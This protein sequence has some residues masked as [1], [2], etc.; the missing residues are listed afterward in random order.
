MHPSHPD[1]RLHG[2]EDL[3]KLD[4]PANDKDCLQVLQRYHA[5]ELGS[6]KHHAPVVRA[7]HKIK[8]VGEVVLAV[9]IITNDQHEAINEIVNACNVDQGIAGVPWVDSDTLTADR[10]PNRIFC[11][12]FGYIKC[13]GSPPVEWKKA[14]GNMKYSGHKTNWYLIME[15]GTGDT[16]ELVTLHLRLLI[17]FAFEL[18]F[19]LAAAYETTQFHHKDLHLE[20]VL[21][22]IVPPDA[23]FAARNYTVSGMAFEIASDHCPKIIDFGKV[24][25][26]ET[27]IAETYDVQYFLIHLRT[28]YAKTSEPAKWIDDLAKVAR[29]PGATFVDVLHAEAFESL[30]VERPPPSKALKSLECHVCGHVATRAYEHSPTYTF[31]EQDKCVQRMA[32]I[33]NLLL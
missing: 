7:T 28:K 13:G 21:S 31:C 32:P 22:Q 19:A 8:L 1:P 5:F 3:S 14:L 4:T 12:T 20:N 26:G 15:L 10:N 17:A 18:F 30:R 27:K 6:G 33:G 25:F 9:K 16:L 24:T 29:R 23:L 11:R 2:C